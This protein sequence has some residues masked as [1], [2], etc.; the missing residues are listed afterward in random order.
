MTDLRLPW[1]RHPLWIQNDHDEEELQDR[2]R[3]ALL[4]AYRRLRQGTIP[5]ALALN[6][7]LEIRPAKLTRAYFQPSIS[8]ASSDSLIDRFRGTA[9]LHIEFE[10]HGGKTNEILEPFPR[11][12]LRSIPSRYL[13]LKAWVAMR[14]GKTSTATLVGLSARALE[15]QKQA[16]GR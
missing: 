13:P 2:K 14:P 11:G 4:W 8:L 10:G 5:W 9:I 15:T 12:V 6:Q 7:K 3:L 16:W 1:L